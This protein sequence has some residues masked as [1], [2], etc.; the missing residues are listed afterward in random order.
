[1]AFGNKALQNVFSARKKRKVLWAD[2]A[3][4]ISISIALGQTPAYAARPRIGANASRDVPVY[5]SASPV[6]SYTC[7]L[8]TSDAADE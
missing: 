3:A 6:P 4:P 5:A 1:M 8:Y 7:L 2:R